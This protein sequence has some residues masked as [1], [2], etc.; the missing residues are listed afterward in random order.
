MMAAPAESG[1]PT[2]GMDESGSENFYDGLK[3]HLQELIAKAVRRA[4]K[5][6]D[7]GCGNCDLAF[8]LA[9][10][11]HQE[12]IGVDISDASFPREA[13]ATSQ[14]GAE[15]Q[16]VKKDA[17]ALTFLRAGSV[18][19]VVSMWALH[20][21]SSPTAVLREAERILRPGGQVL[22]VDFP[23]GSLAQDLWNEDYFAPEEV[24]DMLRKARFAAVRCRVIAGGQIIW[25]GAE[26][27]KTVRRPGGGSR[28]RGAQAF[29][30]KVL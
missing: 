3:P 18:D 16:C 29:D 8:F 14:E 4:G 19:A 13:R 23:R 11:N 10:S 7:V 20:E 22:I 26:K 12:V 30:G 21:M 24:A 1:G 5:V 9:E 17:T 6:L 27:K 25:A 2:L 28:R 15:V